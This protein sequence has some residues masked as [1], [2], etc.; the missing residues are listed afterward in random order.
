MKH[1]FCA[2]FI[3]QTRS[4]PIWF[5]LNA[6]ACLKKSFPQSASPTLRHILPSFG[7]RSPL[8]RPHSDKISHKLGLATHE[9]PFSDT[10]KIT[11]PKDVLLVKLVESPCTERYAR[12]CE[13]SGNLFK[14]PSYSIHARVLS[15]ILLSKTENMG[16]P[17]LTFKYYKCKI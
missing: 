7:C 5:S 2:I 9:K 17:D 6:R 11:I 16:K 15:G 14:F 4:S 3:F 12:W 1:A 10:L 13:R 8:R